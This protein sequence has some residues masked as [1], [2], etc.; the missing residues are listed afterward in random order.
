MGR[1]CHFGDRCRFVHPER[2]KIYSEEQGGDE[3]K[4]VKG[5]RK[6][7]NSNEDESKKKNTNYKAV[8][9][10]FTEMQVYEQMDFLEMGLRKLKRLMK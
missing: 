8:A 10:K 9:K 2:K 1:G 7:D 6:V 3:G 4:D 5:N